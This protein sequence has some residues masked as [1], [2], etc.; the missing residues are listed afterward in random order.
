MFVFCLTWMTCSSNTT[1][2]T[3]VVDR[4]NSF[5]KSQMFTRMST[6]IMKLFDLLKSRLTEQSHKFI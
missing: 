3:F 4:I 6:N 2:N 1:I 5:P